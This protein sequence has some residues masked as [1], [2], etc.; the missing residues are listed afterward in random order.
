[1]TEIEMRKLMQVAEANV[2]FWGLNEL[3]LKIDS[4]R[5]GKDQQLVEDTLLFVRLIKSKYR[6]IML[7]PMTTDDEGHIKP[8]L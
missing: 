6:T 1:M 8:L 2:I 3:I 5:E 4:E 7:T